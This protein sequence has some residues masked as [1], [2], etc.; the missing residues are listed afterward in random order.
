MSS[1][2]L[3]FTVIFQRTI[4]PREFESIVVGLN[5]DFHQGEVPEQAAFDEIR[6]TVDRW[7]EEALGEQL[8]REESQASTKTTTQPTSRPPI[9]G[10]EKLPW[11]SFKVK[12]AA[13]QP[14]E[15]GWIFSNPNM[16]NSTVDQLRELLQR[17]G[18]VAFDIGGILFNVRFNSGGQRTFIQRFPA[19]G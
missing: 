13:A 4:R 10:L 2:K 17:E 1:P 19:K 5:K 3:K 14:E 9:Q 16:P 18:Q 6:G 7:A 8:K 11:K 12:G 15:E